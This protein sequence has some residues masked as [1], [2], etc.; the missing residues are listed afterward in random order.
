MTESKSQIASM[1]RPPVPSAFEQ[2]QVLLQVV[3][4]A[5]VSIFF[6]WDSDLLWKCKPV[7]MCPGHYSLCNQFPL[8]TGKLSRFTTEPSVHFSDFAV[9]TKKWYWKDTGASAGNAFLPS[10][11]GSCTGRHLGHFKSADDNWPR[12][13]LPLLNPCFLLVSGMDFVSLSMSVCVSFYLSACLLVG[14]LSLSLS[15]SL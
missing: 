1:Q 7:P 10:R 9:K 5:S 11:S 4:S 2:D 13:H 8:T 3:P 12:P 6:S 14:L 15:L